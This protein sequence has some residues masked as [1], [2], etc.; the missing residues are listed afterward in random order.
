[1]L[2]YSNVKCIAFPRLP[3]ARRVDS[4]DIRVD[5]DVTSSIGTLPDKWKG[6]AMEWIIWVI[7]IV[8]IVGVVWWLLNRNS[9]ANNTAAGTGSQATSA[10]TPSGASAAAQD[11][12][13][14]AADEA[15]APVGTSTPAPIPGA[16]AP[17]GTPETIPGATAPAAESEPLETSAPEAGRSP[18]RGADWAE[19]PAPDGGD[20]DDWDAG[21]EATPKDSA[22]ARLRADE[23]KAEW[24]A[25]WSEGSS[26]AS[27]QQAPPEHHHEYTQQHSPTLPGAESAAAESEPDDSLS[28]APVSEG[29][30]PR[31]A[32][33]MDPD[34][35][36]R[37]RV[38]SSEASEEFLSHKAEPSGH[39]ATEQPYGEGSAAAAMDGSGPEGFTV[40]G[41]AQTMTYFEETNPAYGETKAGV[42]FESVA[43]AEAAG[44]RPPR[45]TRLS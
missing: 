9:G 28:T 6:F 39:L 44:F 21:T 1:M 30:A 38:E 12:S 8:L 23:D 43:H 10:S 15:T 14:M 25:Q 3:Q 42:W 40:K 36:T 2:G 7:V 24:E 26:T 13:S 27:P 34:A 17:I 31:P 32:A 33:A 5:T 18:D 11:R 16:T 20:V 22:G 29:A 35:E 41:D 37:Q 45:R 19:A 4:L